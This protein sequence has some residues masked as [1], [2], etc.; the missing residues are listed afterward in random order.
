MTV[1]SS[2][3]FTTL[4]HNF[5]YKRRSGLTTLCHI[6]SPLKTRATPTPGFPFLK[7]PWC[8]SPTTECYLMLNSKN[9]S[10][11]SNDCFLFLLHQRKRLPKSGFGSSGKKKKSKHCHLS[12]PPRRPPHPTPPHPT[13]TAILPQTDAA[14]GF[15][16]F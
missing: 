8:A 10:V 13:P 11:S 5:L 3:S 14:T 2:S 9:G 15:P 6:F 4:C 16:S 12:Q 1:A 7:I